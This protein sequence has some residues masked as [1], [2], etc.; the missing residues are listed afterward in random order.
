[1]HGKAGE[2]G[3]HAIKAE[4]L[5]RYK[6]G[7]NDTHDKGLKDLGDDGKESPIEAAQGALFEESVVFVPRRFHR[8]R[9]PFL[10][11]A[12]KTNRGERLRGRI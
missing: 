7:Q 2:N 12:P 3:G 8:L 4:G 5:W 10:L 11:E 9:C 1:M 6:P